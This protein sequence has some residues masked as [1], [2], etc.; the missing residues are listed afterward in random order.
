MSQKCHVTV[1]IL[2]VFYVKMIYTDGIMQ[3]KGVKL[4]S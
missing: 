3:T 4:N 2:A 1:M